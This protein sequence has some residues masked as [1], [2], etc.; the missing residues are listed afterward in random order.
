MGHLQGEAVVQLPAELFRQ[1]CMPWLGV[2]VLLCCPTA[3]HC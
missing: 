2:L 3:T 1:L